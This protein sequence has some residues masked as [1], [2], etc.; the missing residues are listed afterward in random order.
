MGAAAE[1]CEGAAWKGLLPSKCNAESCCTDHSL[2]IT[3]ARYACKH[4]CYTARQQ[5]PGALFQ[6]PYS[7]ASM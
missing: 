6:I 2:A 4:D 3:V 5:Q 7:L 1:G